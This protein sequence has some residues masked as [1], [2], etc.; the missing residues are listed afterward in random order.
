MKFKF[1]QKTIEQGKKLDDE[2]FDKWIECIA[3]I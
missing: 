2:D 1:S 3:N